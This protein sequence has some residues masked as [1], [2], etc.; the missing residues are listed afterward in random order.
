MQEAAGHGE[1]FV[2]DLVG[3]IKEQIDAYG[4]MLAGLA[5]NF[6]DNPAV[7][8]A[9]RAFEEIKQ[10]ALE[11]QAAAEAAAAAP[12][13]AAAGP[14][15]IDYSAQLEQLDK[16]YA[17]TDEAKLGEL[18]AR[19]EQLNEA[20]KIEGIPDD[21]LNKMQV[22]R[23]MTLEQIAA[24]EQWANEMATLGM[25]AEEYERRRSQL[26]DALLSDMDQ[27]LQSI[28][29]QYE[30]LFEVV[31]TEAERLKLTEMYAAAQDEVLAKFQA[32]AAEAQ[33]MADIEA[34]REGMGALLP[35]AE[36]VAPTE[37]GAL[38]G[39]GES[40]GME[41][42]GVGMGIIGSL[43]EML[44]AIDSVA[45]V[46]DPF[47]TIL[48][49]MFS[50]LEPLINQILAPI[51]GVLVIIGQT[52]AQAITP[53]L[54]ALAPIL[55]IVAQ[56]FYI[57]LRPALMLVAPLFEILA[58][59]LEALTPVIEIVAKAFDIV[60]RPIEVLANL[61]QWV[62]RT[63]R[64]AIHNLVEFIKHPFRKRKRDIWSY[65]SLR[66][67]FEPLRR[68]LLDF[69]DMLTEIGTDFLAEEGAPLPEEAQTVIYGGETTV[70]RAPDI[71][72]YQTFQGPIVGEGGT[73]E[74]GRLTA[75]ALER[76]AGI[77]GLIHIEEAIAPQTE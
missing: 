36:A 35:A 44:M 39:I 60:S 48:Q 8:E 46:L 57:S 1:K 61:L 49:V 25:T 55:E 21:V 32:Q 75:D 56:I 66:D 20:F 67:V 11:A 2:T 33:R 26:H 27:E 3:G 4:G 12:P 29:M 68:P 18:Y 6:A 70:Q 62:G 15:P 19:L 74:F 59:V 13:A 76:Y 43:M 7:Q 53:I 10:K 16:L 41:V 77:G 38:M 63:I 22:V 73:E 40:I 28:D 9:L 34:T 64:V 72:I 14:V 58:T 17:Q 45:M 52:L 23:Q 5:E 37:V 30:A 42:A 54:Q 24:T 69:G 51:I 50:I 71:Y 31:E 65:P 47:K